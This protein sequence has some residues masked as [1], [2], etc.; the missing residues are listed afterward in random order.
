MEQ[1]G[2]ESANCDIDNYQKEGLTVLASIDA[3]RGKLR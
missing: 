1:E 2:T 3:A